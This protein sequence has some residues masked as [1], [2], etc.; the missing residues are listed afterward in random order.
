MAFSSRCSSKP[1]T[2]SGRDP[3]HGRL[4]AHC[5]AEPDFDAVLRCLVVRSTYWAGHPE[6]K[7]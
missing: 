4:V 7:A 6:V 1:T 3:T 2:P 5:A